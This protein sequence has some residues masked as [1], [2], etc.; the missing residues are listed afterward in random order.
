MKM[1]EKHT[2]GGKKKSRNRT[3]ICSHKKEGTRKN[4]DIGRFFIMKKKSLVRRS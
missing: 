4:L 2:A 1:L 3:N